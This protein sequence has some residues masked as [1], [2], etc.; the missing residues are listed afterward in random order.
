MV[1]PCLTSGTACPACNSESASE[2]LL[3]ASIFVMRKLYR[4]LRSPEVR[5]T[6]VDLLRTSNT[7]SLTATCHADFRNPLPD[8]TQ[9]Q[10]RS[11]GCPE[12]ART[13]YRRRDPPI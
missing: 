3:E 9:A 10:R 7:M 1:R 5:R 12:Q 11:A 2:E 6:F 8:R 13:E 4:R